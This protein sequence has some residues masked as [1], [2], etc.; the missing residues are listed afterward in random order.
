MITA[1]FPLAAAALLALGVAGCAPRGVVVSSGPPSRG[2]STAATLGIPPGHLPP[3]GEC[4][5]W[6]PGEPPGHQ[7][8]PGSCA[9][10]ATRVPAHG[11]LVFN[12]DGDEPGKGRRGGPPGKARGK[13]RG[14]GNG[15]ARGKR[16]RGNRGRAGVRIRVT[17]Y[18]TDAPEV[19]RW[20]DRSSR[21][22]VRQEEAD[23][24]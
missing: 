17:V 21:E 22:L 14:K 20:Y 11:W 10:L 3:P 12:P 6:V 24:R 15:K 8:P 18:G 16:G 1:R 5:V 2:P 9:T 19:I 13:A 4:R 7:A 23:E